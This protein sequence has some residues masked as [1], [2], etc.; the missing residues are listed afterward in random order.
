MWQTVKKFKNSNRQ[1]KFFIFMA[2]IYLGAMLWT[3][4]QVY[5]RLSYS[6]SHAVKPIIILN[7]ETK[8]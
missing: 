8:S 2:V 4:S 7:D 6:R 3:T 5:S 1:T